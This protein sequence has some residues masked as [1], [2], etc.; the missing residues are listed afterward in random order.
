MENN[1]QQTK[2]RTSLKLLISDILSLSLKAG[3]IG[4]VAMTLLYI[5]VN[6]TS[7]DFV[8]LLESI[9]GGIILGIFLGFIIKAITESISYNETDTKT[10]VY[11]VYAGI[12]NATFASDAAESGF[13]VFVVLF[14]IVKYIYIVLKSMLLIPVS[15]VYLCLMAL[16][17]T[18]FHGFPKVLGN[19]LDK[20]IKFATSIG[21]IAIVIYLISLI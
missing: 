16:L 1:F 13:G 10:D 11:N 19:F 18:I 2:Y 6:R 12:H 20:L 4:A 17:E 14:V 7:F 3:A 8:A 21:C 15:L 9:L 5:L